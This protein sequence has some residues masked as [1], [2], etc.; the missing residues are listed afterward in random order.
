MI[1]IINYGLANLRSV[2]KA[3]EAIGHDAEICSSPHELSSAS[4]IVLPGVSAFETAALN[5]SREGWDDALRENVGNKKKPLLGI[6]L[7]M[8]LLAD[9]SLEHGEHKGLSMIPG[10]VQPLVDI[11]GKLPVPH[12]GWTE[13]EFRNPLMAKGINPGSSFYFVHS[14]YF[15]P[16]DEAHVAAT[17]KYNQ[18]FCCAVNNGNIWAVQ[19]HPEKSQKAGLALLK[20]FCSWDGSSI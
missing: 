18:L 20:N 11:A 14:F 16:K 1:K 12:V 3:F 5:L 15:L 4:H 9:V 13:V 2:Q 7:G 8:Q 17:S 6:C 10:R 19:F